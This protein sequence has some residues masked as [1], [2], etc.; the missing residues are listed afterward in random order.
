MKKIIPPPWLLALT[1]VVTIAAVVGSI[2]VVAYEISEWW[3]YII[4]LLAALLLGYTV[5]TLV[6]IIPT[7]KPKVLE[8]AKR[9][10][11]T[12]NL[13]TDYAFRTSVFSMTSYTL[14]IAFAIFNGVMGIITGAVWYGVMCAYYLA[15]SIMR[16]FV[17]YFGRRAK[18]MTDETVRDVAELKVFRNCG[19]FLVG[20]EVALGGAL[21]QVLLAG[22]PDG[23]EMIVSIGSAAFAFTKIILAIYNFFK[24]RRTKD[25]I[26]QSFRNINVTGA[27]VSLLATQIAL[28]STFSEGDT[29]M[30]ALNAVVGAAICLVTAVMGAAMIVSAMRN[31]KAKKGET[32]CQ[33]N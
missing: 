3:T 20:L 22:S 8:L 30:T 4:Y 26:V 6:F 33:A 18:K 13:V 23:Y 16:V 1:Y 12:D 17:F 32:I 2:C 28:T 25:P 5:Y 31:I 14:N 24:A 15:L 27:M 21:V 29:S 10:D 7:I 9:H 11:F 19:I